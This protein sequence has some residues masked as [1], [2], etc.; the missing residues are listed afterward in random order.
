MLVSN[1]YPLRFQA[2]HR[3]PGILCISKMVVS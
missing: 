3:P 2:V 1:V